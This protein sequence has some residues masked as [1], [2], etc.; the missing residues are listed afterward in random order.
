[1]DKEQEKKYEEYKL[2]VKR[3]E[4]EFKRDNHRIPSKVSENLY[5]YF[6]PSKN[7]ADIFLYNSHLKLLYYFQ[8]DIK[9]APLTVKQAYKMYYRMKTNF[10]SQTLTDV[11]D[12]DDDE[13]DNNQGSTDSLNLSQMSQIASFTNVSPA[14][15]ELLNPQISFPEI[16]SEER[17][18][19]AIDQLSTNEN[20]WNDTLNKPKPKQHLKEPRKNVLKKKMSLTIDPVVKPLRNPKKALSKLT[21]TSSRH[22]NSFETDG[23]DALPD[24]E[25]ILLEKSRSSVSIEKIKKPAPVAYTEL[26][27]SVDRGW[28]TRNTFES[29]IDTT[30]FTGSDASVTNSSSF[31]LSNLNMKSFNSMSSFTDP[32]LG[33]EMT[34]H[35]LDS[36]D[37]EI[38]GNSD[39]EIESRP[40]LHVAKKRRLSNEMSSNTSIESK[41]KALDPIPEAPLAEELHN[42]G[43]PEKPK[44]MSI[45]KPKAAVEQ[46]EK[47][48]IE[49]NEAEPEPPTADKEDSPPI[50][51]RKRSVIKRSKEGLSKI[52][53]KAGKLLRRKKSVKVDTDEEPEAPPEEEINFLIDSDLNAMTTVPRASQKELKTTEKLFDNYLKQSDMP[54]TSSKIGRAI[55]AKTEAKK[56]AL[57]KKIATGTL[58]ENYVRVNLK[59][60]V[61]VRG[62]K[63]F[64]F[65]KYKKSV[66]K[67][68]KAAALSGPEM[69]MRGCDGGVLKCFNCGGVGHFAQHCKQKGDNLLPIDVDVKDESPFPTLEEA[70]QMASDQKLVVHSRKPEQLPQTS[71]DI[72]KLLDEDEEEV[73]IESADKENKDRNSESNDNIVAD[74]EPEPLRK[75]VSL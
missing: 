52:T 68:K 47:I 10:L 62:K 64:S 54:S 22:S 17:T 66:W 13:I 69:D 5:F 14:I 28:L 41:S 19:D 59:K 34:F 72:W 33:A 15:N 18:F 44:R 46:E 70:A 16:I 40:L 75:P 12:D 43:V 1:M 24:L 42:K 31:G 25:T 63:A 71:N 35:T 61:F 6:W 39:D 30:Q 49:N 45:R 32:S 55:D 60:K 20:A 58:N 3:W 2:V 36:S 4:Y 11:L 67:S 65:S 9:D 50:M 26:K 53:K 51:K 73:D 48:I 37:Q 27:N 38:V 57:A 29:S 56:D 8:Y 23:A 7:R 21:L 74:P